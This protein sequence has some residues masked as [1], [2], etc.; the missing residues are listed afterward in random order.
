MDEVNLSISALFLVRASNFLPRAL[1]V[2]VGEYH[3]PTRGVKICASLTGADEVEEVGVPVR[4]GHSRSR[5]A[6]YL[7]GLRQRLNIARES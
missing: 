4:G 6:R 1:A 3:T 2:I 7:H 5:G